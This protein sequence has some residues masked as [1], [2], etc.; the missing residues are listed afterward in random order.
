MLKVVLPSAFVSAPLQ[1]PLECVG[2]AWIPP[3]GHPP[4]GSWRGH[5]EPS[6]GQSE[7]RRTERS[8]LEVSLI[9]GGAIPKPAP[10]AQ[11][12]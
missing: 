6:C 1:G 11:F 4:Q 12:R 7:C 10:R 9:T 8:S 2:A 3:R 5:P